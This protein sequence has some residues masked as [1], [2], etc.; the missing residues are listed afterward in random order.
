[1]TQNLKVCLCSRFP[2]VGLTWASNLAEMSRVDR[3]GMLKSMFKDINY[4]S[5]FLSR[6]LSS[7]PMLKTCALQCLFSKTI[8]L[9][10]DA[11][12]CKVQLKYRY[13]FN[14][15]VET[16]S[17]VTSSIL[18]YQIAFKFSF[19]FLAASSNDTK[20]AYYTIMK[21]FKFPSYTMYQDHS[22]QYHAFQTVHLFIQLLMS[23]PKKCISQSI[24]Y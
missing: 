23:I 4:F 17:V 6:D 22:H 7:P 15:K 14:L 21:K 3:Q 13:V 20:N 12:P 1:M 24:T 9:W 10:L 5:Y 18:S 8:P 19:T 16:L 11:V 2:R